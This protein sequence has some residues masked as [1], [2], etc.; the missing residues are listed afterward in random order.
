MTRLPF[1]HK[2]DF[3]FI[4]IP[5][6][7]LSAC[8]G[9]SES[10]QAKIEP[11]AVLETAVPISTPLPPPIIVP[12]APT[13]VPATPDT[14]EGLEIDEPTA[15]PF[16]SLPGALIQISMQSQVGVLLDEFPVEM[17][18]LVAADLLAQSNEAWLARATRQV[19]LT[20][21]RLTFRD[22]ILSLIHI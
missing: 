20:R 17:R 22:F 19:R 11:T 14:P 12:D 5:L 15:V 18:D 16:A 9:E 4:L 13:D 6:F 1:R 2:L 21:N 7:A 3:F 8:L 10:R